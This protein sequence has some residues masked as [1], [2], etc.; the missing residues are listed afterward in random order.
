MSKERAIRKTI[1]ERSTEPCVVLTAAKILR[2][3]S[4][5]LVCSLESS[6]TGYSSTRL[7]WPSHR[8][9]SVSFTLPCRI[10]R[11]ASAKSPRLLSWMT[12]GEVSDAMGLS[13]S[14]YFW[15]RFIFLVRL[16]LI[17]IAGDR[18]SDW[19]SGI[20][21]PEPYFCRYFCKPSSSLGDALA[22]YLFWSKCEACFYTSRYPL[23]VPDVGSIAQPTGATLDFFLKERSN[24]FS[25]EAWRGALPINS[26]DFSIAL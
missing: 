26:T 16:W 24:A 13:S 8:S 20:S 22:N 15:A 19:S 9:P 17:P 5:P 4:K 25:F 10:S 12:R 23:Y 14:D 2:Y 7:V 11:S 21:C 18:W 6:F 1:A 3:R